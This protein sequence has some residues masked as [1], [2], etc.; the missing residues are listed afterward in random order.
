MEAMLCSEAGCDTS[1]APSLKWN[2][3]LTDGPVQVAFAV[4]DHEQVSYV[5]SSIRTNAEGLKL[6]IHLKQ[7]L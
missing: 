2:I 6:L 5:R 1:V 3:S 7:R 4:A